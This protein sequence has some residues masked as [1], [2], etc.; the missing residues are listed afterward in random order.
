M[1]APRDYTPRDHG[2]L[3]RRVLLA[4]R[5]LRIARKEAARQIGVSV[6]AI[7]ALGKRQTQHAVLD[8]IVR[9][10]EH[11]RWIAPKRGR[12]LSQRKTRT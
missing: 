11:V 4:C 3:R 2:Y 12:L 5:R 9:W 7:R 8:A 6:E 1:K 10:L